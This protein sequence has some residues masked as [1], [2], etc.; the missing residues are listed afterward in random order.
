[1]LKRRIAF[2]LGFVA[3]VPALAACGNDSSDEPTTTAP[4]PGACRTNGTAT[5]SSVAACND[6]GRA[7]CNAELSDKAGSGWAQHYF[8]GDGACAAFNNCLCNCLSSG[9]QNP[10]ECATSACIGQ[11]DAAC[12]TAVRAAQD[13]LDTKCAT[14]CH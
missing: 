6:C 10:L 5:G 7:Q 13:C 8:G 14:E 3:A 11:L 9:P 4:P 12:Q 1:M 2:V